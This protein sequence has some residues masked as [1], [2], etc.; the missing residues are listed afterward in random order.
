MTTTAATTVERLLA[1]TE[2]TGQRGRESSSEGSEFDDLL[3]LLTAGGGGDPKAAK[4]TNAALKRAAAF[5]NW[6][7]LKVAARGIAAGEAAA[8]SQLEPLAGERNAAPRPQ[9]ETEAAELLASL[10]GV[11]GGD[12]VD[13]TA[14]SDATAVQPVEGA[15]SVEAVRSMLLMAAAAERSS[16]AV[17]ADVP[18]GPR[19][20]LALHAKGVLAVR[21]ATDGGNPATDAEAADA[22]ASSVRMPSTEAGDVFS[23]FSHEGEHQSGAGLG[24]DAK[25]TV[26]RTET[27]LAPA[28]QQLPIVQ[29]ADRISE[30]LNEAKDIELLGSEGATSAKLVPDGPVKV[31]LIQLQ[32]AELGTVTVRMALK[33]DT[34]EVRLE[35]SRQDTAER[36]RHDREALSKMLQAAGYAVDNVA[37][38]VVDVDKSF[39]TLQ[40]QHSGNTGSN[41]QSALPGQSQ[42]GWSQ[43]DGRSSGG[44]GG[45]AQSQAG[46]AHISGAGE[47]AEERAQGARSAAG[48]VYL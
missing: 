37:V 20:L 25:Y 47:S 7:E 29:I 44:Q 18:D 13:D 28:M 26:V 15:L 9:T 19:G 27:H 23:S 10:D 4:G 21:E 36:I 5:A 30:A 14:G 16:S 35:V 12:G 2:T 46:Q 38:Q 8:S 32:P 34:L 45:Q 40:T 33:H 3:A 1:V 42:S 43:A 22:D 31:L 11:A 24:A 39:T 17:P 41:G 48:S 6:T